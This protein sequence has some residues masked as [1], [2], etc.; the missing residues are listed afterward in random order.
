MKWTHRRKHVS[1]NE[2]PFS[3][4][5][6][7]F[8]DYQMASLLALLLAPNGLVWA[9]FRAS[10]VIPGYVMPLMM[11]CEFSDRVLIIASAA[12]QPSTKGERPGQTNTNCICKN[13]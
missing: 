1:P 3:S 11:F 7:L 13:Q 12:K 10:N 8:Y 9:S 5:S 4:L 6:C 2:P